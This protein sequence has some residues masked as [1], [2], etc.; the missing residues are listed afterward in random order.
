MLK[1]T[2]TSLVCPHARASMGPHGGCRCL[3]LPFPSSFHPTNEIETVE[4]GPCNFV[5]TLV[6]DGRIREGKPT[7]YQQGNIT[8][9]T[10]DLMESGRTGDGIQWRAIFT[11]P[12]ADRIRQSAALVK[13]IGSR[14]VE[15]SLGPDLD[16]N[17]NMGEPCLA[18]LQSRGAMSKRAS[19][20]KGGAS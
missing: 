12:C 20:G 2:S 18:S 3:Y 15:A 13:I 6:V 9:I 14:F 8:L 5:I 4:K 17:Q 19:K 10:K 16:P 1:W 11:A 7:A